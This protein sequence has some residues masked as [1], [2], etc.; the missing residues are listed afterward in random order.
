MN[1]CAPLRSS[2]SRSLVCPKCSS[3]HA[4]P[5]HCALRV[6]VFQLLCSEDWRSP[7]HW[8]SCCYKDKTRIHAAS[9]LS[10]GVCSWADEG[11]VLLPSEG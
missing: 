1:V 5:Q 6:S 7:L 2:L 10:V 3:V 11:H 4:A 9:L 8:S